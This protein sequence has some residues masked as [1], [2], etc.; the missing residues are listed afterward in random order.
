MENKTAAMV[1]A[2][3]A[4]TAGSALAATPV[5][6]GPP[7][8]VAASYAELLDP[9][10]NAA[11]RL[12]VADA[13]AAARPP[14]VIEVQYH[15]HHHHHPRAWYLSN[16]YYWHGGGWVLRP[17]RHHHHHHHHHHGE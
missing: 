8:P 10:P 13:E 6:D 15:H 11:E 14:G 3:A 12:K 9:I 1:G 4:L 5:A 7:V 17:V 16:G 2:V